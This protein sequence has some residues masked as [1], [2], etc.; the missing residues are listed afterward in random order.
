VLYYVKLDILELRRFFGRNE[1][2]ARKTLDYVIL[3]G[4]LR[5]PRSGYDLS[6]WMAG[7]TSHFFSIGHSSVYPALSRLEEAG[8]VEHRTV[9]SERGPK[10]KVYSI[11]EVGR[12]ALLSWAEEPVVEREVRDEQ[13]V[14]ALCYGFLPEERA[15]ERLWEEKVSHERKLEMYEGFGRGLEAQLREGVISREAY[16][17]TLLTLRRG[18]GAEKGYAEWCEEAAEMISSAA[19]SHSASGPGRSQ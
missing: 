12:E 2:A 10:R 17:G 8:L 16:L 13:L 18:I 6:R 1:M 4:L 15:L 19:P 14:K 7:E 5:Q 11:T 3:A 9:A